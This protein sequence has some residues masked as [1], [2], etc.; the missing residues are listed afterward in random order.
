M[1]DYADLSLADA[2]AQI[3]DKTLSPVDY[4]RALIERIDTY[5]S[6]YNTFVRQTPEMALEHAKQAEADIQ[7]GNWRGALHG[8]PVGLKDII[9]VAGIPTTGHSRIL[10][11]NVPT[12]DAVV[13][14]RLKN[15]GAVLMGKLSTHEFAIG[16]PSFDLPWP[17]ARNAWNR[18]Y[19]PGGS[20]SGSGVAVAAGFMPAALG[21]DTGGSV[22]NP[23]SM[24]GIVG[25]KA[26][27]GRVSRR[28]V[29]PLSYSLDH[30]GPM[31]RTVTDN[32]ILL[33]VIAGH[34]PADPGSARTPVSDFTADLD[35]GVKGLKIGVI[36]R[37]YTQD[38]EA[39]AEMVR[40]IE[41]ALAILADQ[42]ATIHEIDPG[43][44]TDYA[45]ANRVILLSEAYSI[46]EQWLQERPQDYGALA[47]ERIMPGA[48]LRAVDYVHALRQRTILTQ[49]FNQLLATV[50]VAITASSMDPACPIEDEEMCQTVYGRQAR[51]PFNLT[52]NPALALPTGFASSGLPLS[53]QIIGKP[54]D[55]TM[56]YRVARAYEKATEWTSKRP[57][58]S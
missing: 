31:T 19:F 17:P 57:Q 3:R 52:G 22:R 58:L 29:L 39:D 5:D 10:A 47:R 44:L 48:F 24:C 1:T 38:F 9:D 26:T 51:A 12:A 54:F 16:G 4:T 42:G 49:T 41:N 40:S 56:V 27:Y 36:R 21:T 50:D 34:D 46:H 32:A 13:T 8:V 30:V 55:E 37:F 7:A 14:E 33:G 45:S 25:M 43:S 15:A 11:D 18:D 28:G 2:A 23:A 35:K 53:M 6:S 20:S